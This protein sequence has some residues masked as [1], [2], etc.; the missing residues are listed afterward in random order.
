MTTWGQLLAEAPDVAAGVRARFEAHRHKT[1]ATLR[2]DG[3]PRISGT[4]VEVRED[5][6]YLAGM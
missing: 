4:E 1:M 2:A 3:S 6:V 5:G